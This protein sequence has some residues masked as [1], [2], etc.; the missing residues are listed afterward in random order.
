MEQAELI[1]AE[2]KAM[3]D[4]RELMVTAADQ[5]TTFI[6]ANYDAGRMHLLT[7]GK[8]RAVKYFMRVYRQDPAYRFDIEYLIGRSYQYGENFDKALEFYNLY[9]KKLASKANYQGKDKIALPIVDRAIFECE[10]G[11]EFV[12]SPFDFSIVNIG[13]EI[14]SE[15]EDYAPVLNEDEDEI[16]FTTRRREDNLNENVYEDNKPYEDIFTAKK[17]GSDLGIC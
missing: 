15:F 2:T 17:N 5:D 7:V 9:K 8:D 11:K 1:M 16:V 14:N 6:K 3:D 13:R 4:A 10:N 12:S